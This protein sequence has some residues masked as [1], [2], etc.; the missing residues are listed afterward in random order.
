MSSCGGTVNLKKLINLCS[1]IDEMKRY[2]VNVDAE[3]GDVDSSLIAGMQVML[4][5]GIISQYAMESP[6]KYVYFANKPLNQ[7][8]IDDLKRLPCIKDINPH[9]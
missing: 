4:A 3:N 7:K 6:G 9:E 1:V 5:N 8:L 2:A